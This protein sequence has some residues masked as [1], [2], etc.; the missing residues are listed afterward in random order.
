MAQV[1]TATVHSSPVAYSGEGKKVTFIV[2]KG[3]REIEFKIGRAFFLACA[4]M[5]CTVAWF[6]YRVIVP[7]YSL[8]KFCKQN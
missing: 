6:D 7:R 4:R 1:A 5:Y 8:H 3:N 2:F